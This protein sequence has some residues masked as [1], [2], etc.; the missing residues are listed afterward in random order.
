MPIFQ[1]AESDAELMACYPVMRELRPL[2][3]SAQAFVERARLQQ[4][5]GWWLL[6]QW[7]GGAP[8]ALAG[9]RWLENLVHGR[10]VYVD[11]LV[12]TEAARGQHSGRALLDELERMARAEGARKLVLD[13]AM[14]NARAQR[15]YIRCGLL[16]TGLHFTKVLA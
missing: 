5:Q 13:T 2:L 6:A 11:D 1:H 3:H 4:K 10:F 15:F 7:N 14:A 8:T 16:A 9:Y 12:T